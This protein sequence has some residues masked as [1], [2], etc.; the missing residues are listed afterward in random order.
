MTF[1]ELKNRLAWYGD[2]YD[3]SAV[4]LINRR[5]GEVLHVDAVGERDVRPDDWFDNKL[6]LLGS[7]GS[8]Y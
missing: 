6:V 3:W 7:C 5:T 8:P 1:G 2:K 4:V